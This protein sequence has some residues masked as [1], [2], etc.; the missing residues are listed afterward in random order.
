MSYLRY[1]RC[2]AAKFCFEIRATF[3]I[4]GTVRSKYLNFAGSEELFDAK[5]LSGLSNGLEKRF[6]SLKRFFHIAIQHGS[7]V[8]AV[9]N[10]FASFGPPVSQDTRQPNT[11]IGLT[12]GGGEETLLMTHGLLG[13]V[14]QQMSN[15]Q[16]TGQSWGMGSNTNPVN[17]GGL[18]V[19]SG[20]PGGVMWPTAASSQNQNLSNNLWQ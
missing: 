2:R 4:P 17:P 1:E 3:E 11:W 6:T 10:P 13:Q 5:Y 12:S 9:Y 8:T 7:N 14:S 19:G 18:L 20:Q 16:I 15:L